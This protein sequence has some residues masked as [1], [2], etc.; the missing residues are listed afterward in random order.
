MCGERE[1]TISHVVA[2]C[3]KLA[4]KQNKVWRH[5]KV[6]AVIHWTMFE[7]YNVTHKG[8][9]YDH[10]PGRVLENEDVKVLWDF[11]IQTDHKLEYNKPDIVVFEKMKR[12]C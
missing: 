8:K 11:S 6:A 10:N 4:Q 1:E 12:E 7:R 3:K 9:W 5:D 2:E